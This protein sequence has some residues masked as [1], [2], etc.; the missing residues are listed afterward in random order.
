MSTVASSIGP[1]GSGSQEARAVPSNS[2]I[3]PASDGATVSAAP[4]ATDDDSRFDA[5]VEMKT[6][7]ALQMYRE[8]AEGLLDIV[9]QQQREI[10]RLQTRG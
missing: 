3:R 9:K 2:L 7:T 5:L 6:G 10:D 1:T 8:L 4:R